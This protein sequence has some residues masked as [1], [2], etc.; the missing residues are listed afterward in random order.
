MVPRVPSATSMAETGGSSPAVAEGGASALSSV[1]A[2][3]GSPVSPSDNRDSLRSEVHPINLG[4]ISKLK[5]LLDDFLRLKTNNKWNSALDDALVELVES[6]MNGDLDSNYKIFLDKIEALFPATRK[7][8]MCNVKKNPKAARHNSNKRPRRKTCKR[9]RDRARRHE[10]YCAQKLLSKD[11]SS[12][13]K[14]VMDGIKFSKLEESHPSL[15]DVHKFYVEKLEKVNPVDLS[16]LGNNKNNVIL[17]LLNKFCA[18]EV[19]VAI[20]QLKPKTAAG[21]D[22]WLNIATIKSIGAE[23]LSVMFNLFFLLDKIPALITKSCSILIP[24][25]DRAS[26]SVSDWRPITVGSLF[27]RLLAKVL[28]NR[29][30]CFVSHHSRQSRLS[31]KPF[32]V[33]LS[34]RIK[35]RF[36]LSLWVVGVRSSQGPLGT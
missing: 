17:D 19:Q 5:S 26:A 13:A 20:D 35:F 21:P 15:D 33:Q 16:S 18:A 22:R 4:L 10:Y 1:A 9:P 30:S 23:R 12:G 28:V 29:L 11:F 36:Y 24:K 7:G 32:W 31:P 25:T 14:Y 6:A 27:S 8:G 3:A 2:G 34:R